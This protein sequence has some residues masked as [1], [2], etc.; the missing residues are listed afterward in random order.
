MRLAIAPEVEVK[1]E[2]GT[3]VV[4]PHTKTQK[5]RMMWGTTRNNVANMV[6]G[7]AEGFQEGS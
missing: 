1:V 5:A 6:K 3:V 2:N 7:V 4:T